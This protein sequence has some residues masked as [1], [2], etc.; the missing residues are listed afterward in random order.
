MVLGN[1]KMGDLA[2]G[3]EALL[4]AG[5]GRARL[6]IGTLS[7]QGILFIGLAALHG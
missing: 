2:A 7:V 6:Q 3:I 5:P 4:P 1:T